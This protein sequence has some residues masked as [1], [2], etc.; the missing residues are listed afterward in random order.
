MVSYGWCKIRSSQICIL[1]CEK[2]ND[3][4]EGMEAIDEPKQQQKVTS[5]L[6]YDDGQ[7]NVV[8]IEVNVYL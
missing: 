4:P 5:N 2:S 6:H 8:N 3:R 7:S 1:D